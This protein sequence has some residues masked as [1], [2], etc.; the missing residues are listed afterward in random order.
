[1][2]GDPWGTGLV[3]V[4]PVSGGCDSGTLEEWG[5]EGVGDLR[6][7]ESLGNSNPDPNPLVMP[8]EPQVPLSPVGLVRVPPRSPT[9]VDGDAR[10]ETLKVG[11]VLVVKSAVSSHDTPTLFTS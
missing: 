6:S 2:S 4:G 11:S 3:T 8:L 1:M 10:P 9:S 5:H 7:P